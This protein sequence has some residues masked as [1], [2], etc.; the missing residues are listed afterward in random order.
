MTDEHTCE[1]DHP[2][3]HTR[4]LIRLDLGGD[5]S[6]WVDHTYFE[7]VRECEC[8]DTHLSGGG[9]GLRIKDYDGDVAGVLMDASDALILANRLQRAANL[10]LESAEDAPDL[11]REAARYARHD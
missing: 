6:A 4:I 8:G 5:A 10:V 1:H 11:D 9:V 7:G 2:P 3:Q